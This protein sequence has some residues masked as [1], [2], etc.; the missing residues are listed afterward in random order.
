MNIS[1]NLGQMRTTIALEL[2]TSVGNIVM[3]SSLYVV[4]RD[5]NRAVAL[6]APG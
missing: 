3:T 1:S 6:A 5:Q 4:L 2:L